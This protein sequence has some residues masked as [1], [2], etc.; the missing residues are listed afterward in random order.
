MSFK[1]KSPRTWQP[2]AGWQILDVL[3]PNGA[4]KELQQPVQ[5]LQTVPSTSQGELIAAHTP[6]VAPMAM[7]HTPVQHSLSWKQMSPTCVQYEIVDGDGHFPAT[8]VWLQHSL[9]AMQLLPAV[10]H[11]FS[12]LHM[13]LTHC[14]LQHCGPPALHAC[15]SE[16]HCAVLHMPPTQLR[17][18][19]SVAT[20]QLA[21]AW[22]HA[23]IVQMCAAVS[24]WPEQQV[25]LSLQ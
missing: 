10:L 12:G 25:E 17:L 24:Q 19:Q 22:L 21:P 8:Q 18:Q 16:R 5:P 1:H 20:V 9:A 4:Q 7:L 23:P 11:E 14:V 13:P 15:P 3:E 6:A 2:P